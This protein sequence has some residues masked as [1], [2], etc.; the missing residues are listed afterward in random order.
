M[1]SDVSMVFFKRFTVPAL[2]AL[3]SNMASGQNLPTQPDQSIQLLNN[4]MP[5]FMQQTVLPQ[6]QSVQVSNLAFSILLC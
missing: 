5:L 6:N 1:M 2:N 3:V 4:L